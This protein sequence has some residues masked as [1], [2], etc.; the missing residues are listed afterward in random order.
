MSPRRLDVALAV[1][2]LARS[3]THAQRII[4][5]GRARI[6][7]HPARRASTPVP[8][9]ARL[10]VVDVPDGVEYASRAAHKLNGALQELGVTVQDRHCL[11]AG[12]STG[13]FTDVLLRRGAEKVIAVD[14]GHN[15]LAEHLAV[16]PRVTVLD[17]TSVRDLEPALIGGSID[18]LV[19][20]LSFIS[21]RTVMAA[22]ASVVRPR[23]DLLLMVKPQF[24]VGREALPRTG[25]VADAAEHCRA[26]TG[27]ARSAA[28]TGL[29]VAGAGASPLAGQDGNREFFL[30]LRPT[31]HAVTLTDRACDMIESVVTGRSAPGPHRHITEG[32]DGAG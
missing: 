30:H 29:E 24:E 18:L 7:G 11:D 5:E 1:V 13:G 4:D 2:G 19:A 6:D 21:L 10:T 23:G 17:G 28:E 16:D 27:V 32:E 25:V 3:R 15:Q 20:D 22:L 12:A 31:G 26:V 14:I 9:D 8:E